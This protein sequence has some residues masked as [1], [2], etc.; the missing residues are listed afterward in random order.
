MAKG[1]QEKPF[2]LR[3]KADRAGYS[4]APKP[5][6]TYEKEVAAQKRA[7]RWA[8][9]L[10]AVTFLGLSVTVGSIFMHE[11]AGPLPAPVDQSETVGDIYS[12]YAAMNDLYVETSFDK[13]FNSAWDVSKDFTKDLAVLE[14][15]LGSDA[16]PILKARGALQMMTAPE[17]AAYP[18]PRK[19][20]A[21]LDFADSISGLAHAVSDYTRS[22]H[23][24][25]AWTRKFN[26][27]PDQALHDIWVKVDRGQLALAAKPAEDLRYRVIKWSQ[28]QRPK[29]LTQ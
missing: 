29:G 16:G 2:T 3:V 12:G 19:I 1:I 10:L 21:M 8:S 9:G 23:D 4:Y 6:S 14:S 26:K 24:S 17:A 11:D 22:Y 27:F 7:E 28:A 20:K 15:Y 5:V 25:Y 13:V 18:A